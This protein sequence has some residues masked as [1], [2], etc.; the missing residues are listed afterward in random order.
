[1]TREEAEYLAKSLWGPQGWA[2]EVQGFIW[3]F[4]VG[5]G[6]RTLGTGESFDEAFLRAKLTAQRERECPSMARLL[7]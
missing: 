7:A 2:D 3:R 6:E 1:M 5:V 4:G